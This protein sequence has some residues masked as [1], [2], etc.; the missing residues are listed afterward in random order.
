MKLSV[1]VP[2]FNE[3]KTMRRIIDVIRAVPVDKEIL[4]ID[5]GSTDGTRETLRSWPAHPE[6]RVVYHDKNKGKGA[7]VRTGIRE[8]KG[9]AVIIQDADLEYDPM[10]YLLLLNAMQ[11]GGS[12]VV[13][14]SRFLGKKGVSSFWHRGVNQFLTG[15]TNALFDSH[16]TDMETCYKLYRAPLLRSL[17]LSSD[18]FEVEVELAAK[19]LKR[20]EKITEVP[21]SYKG[22]SFGEGKKIGWRD[23]FKAVFA[24]IK[25][26]F[27]G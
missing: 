25:H 26:R 10:D 5:D 20:G 27:R 16:L 4:V 3:N 24:L 15:L 18:G 9:D 12:N 13:Y 17:E 23:G 7:A 22:R 14:G 19:T 2:V 21:I 11:A 8:A 1:I 6:V